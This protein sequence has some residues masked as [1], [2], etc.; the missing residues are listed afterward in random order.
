MVSCSI[1]SFDLICRVVCEEMLTIDF[2][3]GHCGGQLGFQIG[4]ILAIFDLEA[5]TM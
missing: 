3:D 5:A 4:F 1:I 2:Q